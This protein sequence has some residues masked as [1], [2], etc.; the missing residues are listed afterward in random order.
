MTA[1]FLQPCVEISHHNCVATGQRIGV[2]LQ[3]VGS[4]GLAV[5]LAL[6]F[7][8]RVALVA[9]SFIP[10]VAVVIYYQGK[11]I[12]EESRGTAKTL[13]NS[14][15][16]AI[17]AVTNDPHSVRSGRERQVLAEYTARLHQRWARPGAAAHC[18]GRGRRPVPLHVQLY[19]RCGP[20]LRRHLIVK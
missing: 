10:V 15:M 14:T 9:L 8:W 2:V 7:E 11:A 19:Q 3:G 20:H 12:G 17:E 1:A 6:V 5:L 16:I 18:R 13:E 4:I